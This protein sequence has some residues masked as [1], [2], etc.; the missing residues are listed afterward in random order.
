[1][2]VLYPTSSGVWG[3]AGG[4]SDRAQ[5]HADLRSRATRSKLGFHDVVDDYFFPEVAVV[6]NK[7]QVDG[8]RLIG[9]L[10]LE[11][12][13]EHE[14]GDG[15]AVV[16]DVSLFGT[17]DYADVQ[18]LY[19]GYIFEGLYAFDELVAVFFRGGVL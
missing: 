3:Q 13:E 6:L 2:A 14:F 8:V 15:P 7:F 16:Y 9:G 10:S 11:V 17:G 5:Q 1:M 18:F 19:R 12:I 4:R